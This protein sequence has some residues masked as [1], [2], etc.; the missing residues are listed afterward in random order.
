MTV[1]LIQRLIDLVE[2]TA[3]ALWEIA[4][5]QVINTN[6][7]DFIVAVILLI[8]TTILFNFLKKLRDEDKYTWDERKEN[9]QFIYVDNIN[10]SLLKIFG[11]MAT[12]AMSAIAI[13]NILL[14]IMRYLNPDYYA[15]QV[16][17]G[18]IQ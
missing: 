7:R 3:P 4:R 14:V 16:L 8:I 18:L 17:L 2:K 15:I 1:D 13:S 12:F 10:F 6:V 9:S 5:R 11:Y